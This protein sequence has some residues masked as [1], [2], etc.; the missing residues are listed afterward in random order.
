MDNNDFIFLFLFNILRIEI[1]IK[2]ADEPELTKVEYL[3]PSHFDQ[4]SSN[5][6]GYSVK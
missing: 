2:L 6:F 1:E 5:F 4:L 3:T